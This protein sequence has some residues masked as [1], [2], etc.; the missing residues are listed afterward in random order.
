MIEWSLLLRV[1]GSRHTF[2]HFYPREYRDVGSCLYQ[3]LTPVFLWANIRRVFWEGRL[4]MPECEAAC[5]VSLLLMTVPP[6][7][8]FILVSFITEAIL[9]KKDTSTL[10]MT[11]KYGAGSPVVAIFIVRS[12]TLRYIQCMLYFWNSIASLSK[13]MSMQSAYSGCF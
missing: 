7:E 4:R 3:K 10:P 2:L 12:Q 13:P 11:P 6:A 9:L 1:N 5:L 8:R